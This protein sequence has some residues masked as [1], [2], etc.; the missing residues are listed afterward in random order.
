MRSKLVAEV[1]KRRLFPKKYKRDKIARMTAQER[2]INIGW[3][4]ERD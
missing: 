1:I 3:I 2:V 4:M